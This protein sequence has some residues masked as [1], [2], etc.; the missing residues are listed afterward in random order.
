MKM[1]IAIVRP[2]KY[3]DVKEALK[4]KGIM[5]MTFTHVTG[6]GEQAGVKF[7]SRVGDFIVDE[8]EKIKI[9]V[10]LE[11]DD[12]LDQAIEAIRSSACTGHPGDGRIFV[13]PV[14]QSYKISDYHAQ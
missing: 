5:G 12:S 7:T 13:V 2:E 14:E 11:S 6:R 9:E 1:I 4:Q 3:E 10:V 8:I